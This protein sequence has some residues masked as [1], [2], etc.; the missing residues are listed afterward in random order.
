MPSVVCS[1][2]TG[3]ALVPL[4]VGTFV[5]SIVSLGLAVRIAPLVLVRV[6]LL[7]EI[8]G[9]VALGLVAAPDSQGWSIALALFAFGVGA[10]FATAQIANVI[11]AEVPPAS[12]GRGAAING[13]AGQVGSAFGIAVLPTTFYSALSLTV[14]DRLG[15]ARVPEQEAGRI[16]G[17]ITAGAGSSIG[18]LQADLAEA[19]RAAMSDSVSIVGYLAAGLLLVGLIATVLIPRMPPTGVPGTVSAGDERG[20]G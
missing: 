1:L 6:G 8:A 14:Q 3:L 2:D 7:L 20:T 12:T 16:A 18:S 19:A 13:T 5:A 15:T 9:L 11:F 17:E 10:G 4:A